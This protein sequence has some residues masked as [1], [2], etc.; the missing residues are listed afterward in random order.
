MTVT[1]KLP[2]PP[3]RPTSTSEPGIIRSND[4]SAFRELTEL[5][6]HWT[7]KGWAPGR[8]GFYWYLTFSDPTLADL[9]SKCQVQ[10]GTDTLDHVPLDS[11]HL[12]VLS[13]GNTDQVSNTELTRLTELTRQRLAGINSF[14]LTIG[15]LVGSRSAI[16]F[17]VAPWDP[18]LELHRSL[19]E[20]TAAVRP[21]SQL[22]ETSEFRPHLGIAYI[23]VQ[24]VANGLVAAVEQLRDLAPV[25][26]RVEDVH[27]VELRRDGRQYVWRDHAVIPFAR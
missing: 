7:L 27:I 2:F 26:V 3:L 15:P 12:T 21:S 22:T 18:L 19:R 4:W 17:S 20:C 5:H 13:I 1:S 10:L 16:R 14:D 6:D 9:A 23:N 11:L 8:S 25:T 24:Q